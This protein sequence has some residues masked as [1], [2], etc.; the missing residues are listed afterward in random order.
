M[1][2]ALQKQLSREESLPPDAA[3]SELVSELEQIRSEVERLLD[4]SDDR[5][6]AN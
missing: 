2:V 3:I 4:E 5:K 1:V 6:V